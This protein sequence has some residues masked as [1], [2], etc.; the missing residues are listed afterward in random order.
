MDMPFKSA[1]ESDTILTFVERALWAKIRRYWETGTG[2]DEQDLLSTALRCL[3]KNKITRI[4]QIVRRDCWY[5]EPH[6]MPAACA[7]ALMDVLECGDV[8]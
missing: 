7:N 1:E 4:H 8:V 3:G 2:L 5:L 6:W